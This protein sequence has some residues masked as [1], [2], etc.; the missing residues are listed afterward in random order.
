L[1]SF[2][3]EVVMSHG[4]PTR[5]PRVFLVL[6]LAC[7]SGCGGQDQEDAATQQKPR[8]LVPGGAPDSAL[9]DTVISTETE[10]VYQ[11]GTLPTA[12]GVNEAVE[13][14]EVETPEVVTEIKAAPAEKKAPEEPSASRPATTVS[15]GS[16]AYS[17]QLGSF[18]SVDNARKQADRLR[19]LGY[20]PV[21]EESNLG[22]QVYH[23][24]ML[25]G[26][27]DMAEAS[28][29]GEFIHSELGIA[30]LVRRGN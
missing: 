1:T 28:R 14:P 12:E 29:L 11:A 30:Y 4:L 22:G 24:V 15:S 19:A 13:S 25:R 27:G 2:Y 10:S 9:V 18:T 20:A 17:L 21:I 16:G 8:A 3:R 26:V 5:R 23:R 6:V 7:L